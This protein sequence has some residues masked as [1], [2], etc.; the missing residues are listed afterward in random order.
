M[1]AIFSRMILSLKLDF[2]PSGLRQG[3]CNLSGEDYLEKAA[4]KH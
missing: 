1:E 2:K 3:C 4:E